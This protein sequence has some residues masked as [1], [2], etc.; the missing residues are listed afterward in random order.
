MLALAAGADQLPPALVERLAQARAF[1]T[2]QTEAFSREIDA[3]M[4]AARAQLSGTDTRRFDACLDQVFGRRQIYRNEC[5]GVHFPFLP[6]YDFFD[7]HHF[8]WFAELEAKT[9][10]IR[11]ELEAVIAR[12]QTM[13][14]YVAMDPGTPQNKW[15]PLDGS[16]DWSAYF[17]WEY[18]EAKEEACALCPN[19]VAALQAVPH[20][21]IPGRAPTAFFSILRPRTHIPPHTGVT[22]TRAVIHL[23]LIIPEGCGIR[24]GGETRQWQVGEAMAF[25]DTIEHEAWNDSDELRAVLIFDVWNPFLTQAER[26]L[27]CRYYGLAESSGHNPVSKG[28][29]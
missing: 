10:L 5:A 14:P 29:L 24:V 19:T 26:D 4:A 7:R 3:G 27:L 22:N 8:P 2:E 17:L 9:D 13:R 20:A 28:P 6:A 12:S 21:K 25:D 1:V 11:A 23:P 16:L 18:G 15:S